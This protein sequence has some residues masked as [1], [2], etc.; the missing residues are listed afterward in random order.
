MA[1]LMGLASSLHCAGMCGPII[2]VMPFQAMKGARRLAGIGLYHLGR[3]SIYALLGLVLFSFQ[4]FFQPQVQQY[5]SIMLGA[6]LLIAGIFTFFPGKKLQFSLPWG[7]WVQRMLGRFMS[8]PGLGALLMTGA[9]NGLLPC[10]MVYMAL[11]AAVT[12]NSAPMAASLMLAFG[13]GT[14]PMLI[15]L[16]L[17]RQ[18][19]AWLRI[20]SMRRLAPVL[21]FAF[22]CLFMLRGMNLGIPYISPK[23]QVA[24][25]TITSSCCHKE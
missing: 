15:A 22:G 16:T 14:M 18:K 4:S 5:I 8:R 23:V 24:Q 3:I 10:G 11:S 1:L 19:A 7:Q 17:L 9:L 25:H 21:M 2:W 13:A 6:G 20:D 12:A